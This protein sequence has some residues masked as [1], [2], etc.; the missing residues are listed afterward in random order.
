MAWSPEQLGYW[1]N[2]GMLGR[3]WADE[4]G[5]LCTA[6]EDG[7][8]CWGSSDSSGPRE[9]SLGIPLHWQTPDE[10]WRSSSRPL[11]CYPGKNP[12]SSCREVSSE[13]HICSSWECLG[14]PEN[15]S[16][17]H[18][19][20]LWQWGRAQPTNRSTTGTWQG[21]PGPGHCVYCNKT[22]GMGC[23]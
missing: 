12:W 19:L 10:G 8:T 17:W 11:E 4:L 20:L 21:Q 23:H 7:Y 3:M 2:L 5:R 14:M 18:K 22:P 6:L 9:S 13:W 16:L 1:E 15:A